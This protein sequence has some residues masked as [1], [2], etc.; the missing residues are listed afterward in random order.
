VTGELSFLPIHA[1]GMVQEDGIVEYA[2]DYI[3]SSYIPTLAALTKSRVDW[4]VV[5]H[6][7]VTG[8]LGACKNSPGQAVLGNVEWE[9]DLIKA[10]FTRSAAQVLHLSSPDTTSKQ[11]RTALA[12]KCPHILHLAC[13][14]EQAKNPL[15][16]AF[17]LSDGRLSIQDLMDIR[18][19]DGVLAF[20][21]AC[22]TAKGS[23][24]QP[25]QAVHLAASML[26]CG[27]RSVVGTMW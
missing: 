16:S 8:I 17:L 1:A 13:H 4:R 3:V 14:G 23:E 10:C 15:D 18:L 5:P 25:D 27:F 24:R 26:F 2:T 21:S 22:Q 19:P 7:E 9:I 12:N 20:L 11:L 6:H